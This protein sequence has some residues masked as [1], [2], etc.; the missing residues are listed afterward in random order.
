MQHLGSAMPVRKP[1]LR[2]MSMLSFDLSV[3]NWLDW[4]VEVRK[5]V[6][7]LYENIRKICILT[8]II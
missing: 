4:N 6:K 3:K 7:V 1:N 5:P 8:I 2:I